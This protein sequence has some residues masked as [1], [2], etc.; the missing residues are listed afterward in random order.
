MHNYARIDGGTVAEI[1]TTTEDIRQLFHP[2]LH[3]VDITG[4]K[5]AV[6]WK[7]AGKGTFVAPPRPV[8][9][10]HMPTLAELHAQLDR[11]TAEIAV[12]TK[13]ASHP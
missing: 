6:G 3:W 2:S 10:E 4:Q 9:T 8:A 11:I 5:L 12:L 1:I 13:A 7:E